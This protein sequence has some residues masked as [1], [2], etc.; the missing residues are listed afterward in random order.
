MFDRR[1]VLKFVRSAIFAAPIAAVTT[2][3]RSAEVTHSDAEWRKLLGADRYDVL[4]DAGTEY[5]FSS[6]LL[7]EHRNGIFAC[8]GCDLDLYAS[9]T[10][11]DSGTGWPS[12]WKALD[13]AIVENQDRSFGSIRTAV[14]CSRC[15]GHLGHVFKDGPKPTGLR[16]CMNGLALT[17]KPT[18]A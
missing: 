18:A 11:Y 13:R 14:S 15:D 10:K 3:G 9:Q 6:K 4:R 2:A 17:F 16:Y 1:T 5:A 12:F 7:N 8:A